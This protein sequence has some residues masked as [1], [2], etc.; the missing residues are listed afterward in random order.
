[1]QLTSKNKLHDVAEKGS[2]I[3]VL[4]FIKPAFADVLLTWWLFQKTIKEFFS[5]E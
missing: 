5:N 4:F 2:I 1:M 3:S